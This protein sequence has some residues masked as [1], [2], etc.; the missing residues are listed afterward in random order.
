VAPGDVVAVEVDGIGRLENTV[1]EL[2]RDLEPVG[3]QPEITA[4]T[5]HVAL[6]VPE[7]EAE[8]MV[9]SS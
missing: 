6:A 3:E 8:R 5:L 7:D 9:G 1:V 4:N 2:E